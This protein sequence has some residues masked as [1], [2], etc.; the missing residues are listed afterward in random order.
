MGRKEREKKE[1]RRK[2]KLSNKLDVRKTTV[3]E[4]VNAIAKKI[5][6]LINKKK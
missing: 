3:Q 5:L 2:P 4:E 6:D 1:P